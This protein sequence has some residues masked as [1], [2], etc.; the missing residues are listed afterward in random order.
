MITLLTRTGSAPLTSDDVH[1]WAGIFLRNDPMWFW[2][3]RRSLP[4]DQRDAE[5]MFAE[6]DAADEPDDR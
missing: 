4:L 5:K 6:T 3:R 2:L 1:I